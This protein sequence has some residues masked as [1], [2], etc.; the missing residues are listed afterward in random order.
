MCVIHSNG[1]DQM[2]EICKNLI[3]HG[4]EKMTSNGPNQEV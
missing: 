2:H 4:K 3:D 1:T